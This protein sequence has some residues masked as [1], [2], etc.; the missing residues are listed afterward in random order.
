L[1]ILPESE[2]SLPVPICFNASGPGDE[3]WRV[4]KEILHLRDQ[5][6]S[7]EDIGV[8]AREVETSYPMFARVFENHH[9]PFATSIE[10]PVLHQPD[11]HTVLAFLDILQNDFPHVLVF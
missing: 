3:M 7:F 10:V 6:I 1:M 4:A 2:T 8:V 9:I 5:G 11:A